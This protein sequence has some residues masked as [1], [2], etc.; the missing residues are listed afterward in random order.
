MTLE[1]FY[2]LNKSGTLVF[3]DGAELHIDQYTKTHLY[4]VK[5]FYAI[6]NVLVAVVVE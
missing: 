2:E 6:C 4:T 1:Q 3:K 5:Y